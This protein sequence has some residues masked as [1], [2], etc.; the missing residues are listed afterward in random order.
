MPSK[1]LTFLSQESHVFQHGLLGP[2][3]LIINPIKGLCKGFSGI[4]AHAGWVWGGLGSFGLSEFGPRGAPFQGLTR[5][6]W[7]PR[8]E[9]SGLRIAGCSAECFFEG[10]WIPTLPF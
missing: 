10:F 2:I 3:V 7:G 6:P 5:P 8:T 1:A 4:L 9:T